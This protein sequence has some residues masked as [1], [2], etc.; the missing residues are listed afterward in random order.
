MEIG[1][2]KLTRMSPNLNSLCAVEREQ[3]LQNACPCLHVVSLHVCVH[4]EKAH[5]G[6]PL[7]QRCP[8][9]RAPQVP[10][11]KFEAASLIRYAMCVGECRHKSSEG[12]R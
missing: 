10:Q 11:V 6:I 8:G 5:D 1:R 4:D 12:D 9:E 2:V 3:W 7:S